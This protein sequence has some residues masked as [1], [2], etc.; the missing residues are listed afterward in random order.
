MIT[1]HLFIEKLVGDK[2][3]L[4][5]VF[6]FKVG[7][8]KYK[9]LIDTGGSVNYI[10]DSIDW[11]TKNPKDYVMVNGFGGSKRA[12]KAFPLE[13]KNYGF[14]LRDLCIIDT[15]NLDVDLILGLPF[16]IENKV[17]LVFSDIHQSENLPIPFR[18]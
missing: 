2:E 17:D 1:K 11:A 4:R 5:L 10:S 15:D 14:T 6:L 9:G 13:E 8:T 12:Y 3:G 16:L 18:F 7:D